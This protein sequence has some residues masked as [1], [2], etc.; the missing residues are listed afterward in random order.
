MLLEVLEVLE[1]EVLLLRVSAVVVADGTTAAT[2]LGGAGD[3]VGDEL[4]GDGSGSPTTS[5]DTDVLR[6]KRSASERSGDATAGA[7]PGT[8]TSCCT[9]AHELA[10]IAML[11]SAQTARREAM[12]WNVRV[13]SWC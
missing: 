5:S 2:V 11:A 1:V 3:T 12:E 8:C 13:M 7:A 9:P 10:A 6:V 4:V